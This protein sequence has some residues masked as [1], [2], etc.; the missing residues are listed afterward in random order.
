MLAFLI[1]YVSANNPPSPSTPPVMTMTSSLRS[2]SL[3]TP[4]AILSLTIP[5]MPMAL[6]AID[7]AMAMR[8][9]G[10]SYFV[11]WARRHRTTIHDTNGW[12]TV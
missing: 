7:Q 3:C 8:I 10:A 1:P 6:I 9:S 2:T 11:Y 12:K 5:K 4:N